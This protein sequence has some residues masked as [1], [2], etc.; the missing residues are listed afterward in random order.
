MCHELWLCWGCYWLGWLACD[1]DA[2]KTCSE[3]SVC[4]PVAGVFWG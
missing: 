2:G 4:T 3:E 1:T